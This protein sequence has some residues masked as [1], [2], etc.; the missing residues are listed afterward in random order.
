[1][2]TTGTAKF[3]IS[4]TICHSIFSLPVNHPFNLLSGESLHQL[5]DNLRIIKVIIIDEVSILGK[6]MYFID[7]RLKQGPGRMDESFDG[8]GII[9][10]GDF[11][12]LPP[13]GDTPIYDE[14]ASDSYSICCNTSE[15][16]TTTR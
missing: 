13:I 6:K 1:M 4:G 15:D 12:Q 8:F 9:F 14:D 2:G 10:V 16:S 3:V 5:Q 11:Q 7:Q